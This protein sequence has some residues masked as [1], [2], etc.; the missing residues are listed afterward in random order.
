MTVLLL[1]EDNPGFRHTLK[2]M[3]ESRFPSAEIIEAAGG[4]EALESIEERLPDLIFMDIQLP[5]E[6][7]LVLTK[8]IKAR[9]PRI[10]III[11]TNHDLPEY[12]QAAAEY[13]A[14]TFLSKEEATSG[15][16]IRAVTSLLSGEVE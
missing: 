9:Y 14:D 8:R 13:G 3:L 2:Q 1:V 12:R 15:D 4:L 16:I 11:L 5:D 10:P 7:G 6:N